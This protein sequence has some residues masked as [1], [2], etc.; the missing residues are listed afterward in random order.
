MSDVS[1]V[2]VL[3][4]ALD[5]LTGSVV[6][7]SKVIGTCIGY[8]CT[9]YKLSHIEALSKEPEI[10]S[11][12]IPTRILI[13]ERSATEH[14]VAARISNPDRRRTCLGIH[15]TTSCLIGASHHTR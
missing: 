14:V 12:Q 11:R 10:C 3:S 5:E 13:N 1:L 2:R 7:L 8:T 15:R 6:G 9:P 4:G